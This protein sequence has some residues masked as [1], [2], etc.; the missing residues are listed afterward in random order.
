MIEVKVSSYGRKNLYARWTS[1]MPI[2]GAQKNDPAGISV[3]PG[4][5]IEAFP[6]RR[7]RCPAQKRPP[8]GDQKPGGPTE[9][10]ITYI[11]YNRTQI[12]SRFAVRAHGGC[13]RVAAAVGGMKNDRKITHTMNQTHAGPAGVRVAHV[14][15][16]RR[17]AVSESGQA[18]PQVHDTRKRADSGV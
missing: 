18:F 2:P 9:A 13:P 6:W 8:G 10:C 16:A 11:R 3:F 5:S 14:L 12:F 17:P 15:G 7:T 4:S 1:L